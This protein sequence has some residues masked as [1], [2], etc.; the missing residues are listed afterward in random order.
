L[1]E[2]T[3]LTDPRVVDGFEHEVAYFF[4]DRKKGLVRKTVVFFLG[5]TYAA[6]AEVALSHEHEAFVFLPFETA[7]TRITFPTARQ[8]LRLA[9][10]TLAAREHRR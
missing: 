8:V 2:E 9:E 7:V 1:Q 6:D 4:R 5:E 3:G 10:E